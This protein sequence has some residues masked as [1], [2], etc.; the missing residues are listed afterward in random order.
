MDGSYDSRIGSDALLLHAQ[1]SRFVKPS[2]SNRNFRRPVRTWPTQTAGI[3][4]RFADMTV[5]YAHRIQLRGVSMKNSKLIVKG[6]FLLGLIMFASACVV[7]PRDGYYDH[8]HHR[9][10][11][12]HAWHECVEHDEHCG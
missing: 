12:D 11:H 3:W 2:W 4:G 1:E 5:G 9:Y 6:G 10:Y 7:V 8:D